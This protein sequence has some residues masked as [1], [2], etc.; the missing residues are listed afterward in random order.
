MS[1][2]TNFGPGPEVA[3]E[4]RA[5]GWGVRFSALLAAEIGPGLEAM[6]E[7]RAPG[8]AVCFSLPFSR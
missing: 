1:F 6:A 5:S 8:W 2:A 4:G 7:G 3:A